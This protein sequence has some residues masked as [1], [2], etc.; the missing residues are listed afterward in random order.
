MLGG[1]VVG[2]VKHTE[3]LYMVAFPNELLDVPSHQRLLYS[4]VEELN[5]TNPWARE[6]VGLLVRGTCWWTPRHQVIYSIEMDPGDLDSEPIHLT[7]ST[8]C[9]YE[10]PF[11]HVIHL[12]R[13]V[14][15]LHAPERS[16]RGKEF[17]RIYIWQSPI[18]TA[19]DL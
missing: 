18:M 10:L 6:I 3:R 5:K 17:R 12:I 14:F 16:R 9:I 1:V 19:M 15:V 8:V 13:C 11:P 4:F 2:Y 7:K